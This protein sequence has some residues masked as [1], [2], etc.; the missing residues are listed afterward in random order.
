MKGNTKGLLIVGFVFILMIFGYMRSYWAEKE[1]KK[2]GKITIA[3]IDSIFVP[4]KWSSTIYLSYYIDNKKCTSSKEDVNYK[5]SKKDIGKF[6][7]FKYLPNSPRIVRL[8]FSKQITDTTAILKAGFS[9]EEIET[10][11][12]TIDEPKN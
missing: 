12:F 6:Y 1:L 10:G 8:N 4:P 3:R 9:R 5:S 2:D 11:N 7:E